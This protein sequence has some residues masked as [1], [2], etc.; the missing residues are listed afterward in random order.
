MSPLSNTGPAG[1]VKTL[2]TGF[3]QL[4]I[5]V[6]TVKDLLTHD[7]PEEDDEFAAAF[8][9][10]MADKYSNP[11]FRPRLSEIVQQMERARYGLTHI[12]EMKGGSGT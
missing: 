3:E 12:E 2:R 7:L 1:E 4:R 9:R 6:I 5:Q 10:A 11:R 8:E